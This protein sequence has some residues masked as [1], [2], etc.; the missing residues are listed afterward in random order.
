MARKTGEYWLYILPHSYCNIKDEELLIY[1]T[2]TGEHIE[3]ENREVIHL[4]KELHKKENLGAILVAGKLLRSNPYQDFLGD[5]ISKKMGVAVP[6]EKQPEKPIQMMPILNL[7]RDIDR[8][9]D[10]EAIDSGETLNKY[11]WEL[12]I[13]LTDECKHHC[14]H[15]SNYSRQVPC[16][17]KGNRGSMS[18]NLLVKIA[19]QIKHTSLMRLNFY[20][21]DVTACEVIGDIDDIF[22]NFEGEIKI[23]NHF[24][25]WRGLNLPLHFSHC[26]IITFPTDFA[27]IRDFWTNRHPES[28]M[29]FYFVI[30]SES[31]YSEAQMIIDSLN[32]E[33]YDIRPFYTGDNEGFFREFI[34][35]D[36]EEILS[37]EIIS[38]RKIFSRQKMNNH[39]FGKLT[40]FPDGSVYT[41]MGKNC[42]GDLNK[43]TLLQ[44][45]YKEL[46]ENTA[47]RRVRNQ[48]PCSDCLLQYLCPSPSVY[49]IAMGKYNLCLVK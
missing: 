15:C 14:A 45:I 38:F 19:S 6:V 42:I 27:T 44:I 28:S 17:E 1:H 47:W 31:E 41:M 46:H 23:F 29:K 43:E 33:E 5:F 30:T 18:K 13:Y 8:I 26:I 20:G 34:M 36:K 9:K 37:E 25:N 32:L 24:L 10:K 48:V 4:F 21:G 35:Q 16:C 39:F 22:K 12:D 40:I 3:T 11:L 49:E 2:L 7:Q